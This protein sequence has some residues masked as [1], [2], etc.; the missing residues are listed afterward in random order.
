L[1][2]RQ[3]GY[4]GISGGNWASQLTHVDSL[5][6]TDDLLR[7]WLRMGVILLGVVFLLVVVLIRQLLVEL[8]LRLLGVLTVLFLFVVVLDLFLGSYLDLLLGRRGHGWGQSEHHVG[9]LWVVGPIGTATVHLL[10]DEG[11]KGTD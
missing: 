10:L 1:L 4:F 11:L 2:V 5:P 9:I 3:L 7:H 6:M 8:G